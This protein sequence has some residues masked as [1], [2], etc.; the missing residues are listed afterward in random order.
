ML[1]A[2]LAWHTVTTK[3][4]HYLTVNRFHT[5]RVFG[6]VKS[7]LAHTTTSRVTIT[8]A[9]PVTSLPL[10]S[11]PSFPLE[12]L[13]FVTAYVCAR[14]PPSSSGVCDRYDGTRAQADRHRVTEVT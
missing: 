8:R 7:M 2:H 4:R 12:R 11:I 1:A 14:W 10:P 6:G 5:M 9:Y 3:E 13:F